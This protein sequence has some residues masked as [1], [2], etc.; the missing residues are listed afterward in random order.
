MDLPRARDVYAVARRL[1]DVHTLSL[2]CQWCLSSG[3]QDRADVVEARSMVFFFRVLEELTCS[4]CDAVFKDFIWCLGRTPLIA[5]Q[6]VLDILWL[7]K[8]LVIDEEGDLHQRKGKLDD[9]DEL[10]LRCLMRRYGWERHD[11][12]VDVCTWMECYKS[13]SYTK[14]KYL[15]FAW[16]LLLDLL[17]PRTSTELDAL[18]SRHDPGLVRE[19][20]DSRTLL[21]QL[22][23]AMFLVLSRT[24]GM[25]ELVCEM[26]CLVVAAAHAVSTNAYFVILLVTLSSF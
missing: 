20:R 2:A 1:W 3:Y 7:R 26:T 22:S 18:R 25:T 12:A 5:V 4:F 15:E 14:T 11:E 6:V 16:F 8:A 17:H 9:S 13:P 24:H 19:M 21:E 23:G 10:R